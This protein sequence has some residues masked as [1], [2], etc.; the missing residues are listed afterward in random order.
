MACRVTIREEVGSRRPKGLAGTL[1]GM[2]ARSKPEE[3]K[4]N[5]VNER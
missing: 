4:K 2:E 5:E 1:A 3:N